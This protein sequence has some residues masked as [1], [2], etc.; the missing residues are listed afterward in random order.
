MLMLKFVNISKLASVI[1]CSVM[2]GFLM[3]EIFG[4]YL[5]RTTTTGM[6]KEWQNS[7]MS[8]LLRHPSRR[9]IFLLLFLKPPSKERV[10]LRVN[11]VTLFS[12]AYGKVVSNLTATFPDLFWAP[13]PNQTKPLLLQH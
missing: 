4:K 13:P 8:F 3:R 10:P 1:I 5:R 11:F 9:H 7:R 12:T 2:F 6:R